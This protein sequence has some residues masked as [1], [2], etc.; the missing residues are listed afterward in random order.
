MVGASSALGVDGER[1]KVLPRGVDTRRYRPGL[2][3]T[4]LRQELG[5]NG[6]SPIILSPRYQ[7]SET[8]YNCDIVVEAMAMLRTRF[9]QIACIQLYQPGSAP[10]F[11]N[12]RR[13]AID[14]GLA[15]RYKLVPSVDNETMPLYYNL[16]DVTVSVPSSD[17]FPVTVLE[18][19]A[20]GS[21]L[22]VSELPYCNEWFV[23]RENGLLVPPRDAQ[24]LADAVAELCS[25]RDA[26]RRIASTGR[27]LVEAE[28]DYERCM[29]RLEA[30]YFALLDKTAA[31]R[32]PKA[33]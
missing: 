22:V 12:L 3:T 6:L 25:D 1:V 24:A 32:Q 29:D 26:A 30:L 28:A 9:P 18:A 15:D 33:T 10:A 2:D 23:S 13:M 17:G 16:A 19:S 14:S 4:P 8:L 5:L 11:E 20:C 27:R 21:P 7:I 31:E